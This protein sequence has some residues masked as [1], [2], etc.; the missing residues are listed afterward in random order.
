MPRLSK[1]EKEER[2]ARR[3]AHQQGYE[4]RPGALRGKDEAARL[5]YGFSMMED[6]EDGQEEEDD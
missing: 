3:E 1:E 2:K 4:Y 6:S 5:A